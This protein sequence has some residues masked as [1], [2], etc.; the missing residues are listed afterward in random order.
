M[1]QSPELRPRRLFLARTIRLPGGSWRASGQPYGL[2]ASR[3]ELFCGDFTAGAFV[4]PLRSVPFSGSKRETAPFPNPQ[5]ASWTEAPLT[6][7][8]PGRTRQTEP[9]WGE[10]SVHYRAVRLPGRQ[11]ARQRT[12]LRAGG[13]PL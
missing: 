10:A 6:W 13:F 7:S 9:R 2:A 12:A 1:S 3:F 5:A 4:A 8:G 11:A